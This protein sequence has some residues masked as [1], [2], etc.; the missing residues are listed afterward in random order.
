MDNG[1][2]VNHPDLNWRYRGGTNSWYDPRSEYDSPYDPTGHGTHTMGVMVGGNYGGTYIGVAPGA[3][4]ISAKIFNDAGTATASE[5]HLGFQWLLDPDNDANTDDAPDIVNNSWGLP[6]DVNEC[7]LEFYDDVQALRTAG[8]AVVFAAGNAGPASNTSIS[9]ANYDNSFAVGSL[10]STKT[11]DSTSGRGPSSCY[12]D[13][14]PHVTAPGVNV[15]VADLTFGGIMPD[16]F[17][18]RSGTSLA[19]PHVSGTMALLME[20]FP[21]AN[22]PQ[23]EWALQTAAEDLGVEGPDNDYGYGLIDVLKAYE[24]ISVDLNRDQH[25]DFTDFSLL[26][27]QWLENG[28]GPADWCGRADTDR[29]SEVGLSDMLRLSIYWLE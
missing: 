13:I 19:A 24:L 14:Y 20:A 11:I 10:D 29:N 17:D 2:D 12:G 18:Y 4:W 23:I 28:C 21:D 15:R 27:D 9:P 25:I 26:G 5:I 16:S 6:D 7:L 8:I 3:E 1:V 22:V